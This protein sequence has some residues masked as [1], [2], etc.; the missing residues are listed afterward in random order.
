M[1]GADAGVVFLYLIPAGDTKIHLALADEGGNIG[2]WEEDQGNG[3]VLDEGNV[4]AVFAAELDVSTF[5]K[6]ERGGI[7]PSL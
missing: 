6:I 4:E 2:G 3:E 5:E 7:Q 1:R